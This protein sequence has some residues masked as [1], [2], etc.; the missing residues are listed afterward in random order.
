MIIQTDVNLSPKPP[1]IEFTFLDDTVETFETEDLI[2]KDI[3]FQVWL[4]ANNMSCEYEMEGKSVDD[5]M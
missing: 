4:K 1:R 5:S 2:A 3:L